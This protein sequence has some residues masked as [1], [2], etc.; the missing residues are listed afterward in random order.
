MRMPRPLAD[1]IAFWRDL[2]AHP[3]EVLLSRGHRAWT[4]AVYIAAVHLPWLTDGASP[5]DWMRFVLVFLYLNLA[6]HVTC[7]I[8]HVNWIEDRLWKSVECPICDVVDEDEEQDL[9][10]TTAA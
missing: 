8:L 4:S 9:P 10:V 5:P 2:P 3:R 6:L 7:W 1:V